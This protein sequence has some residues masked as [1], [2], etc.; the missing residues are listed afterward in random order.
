M[1]ECSLFK[2]YSAFDFFILIF[3]LFRK[4]FNYEQICR[5]FI[6]YEKL[7]IIWYQFK[8]SSKVIFDV[9]VINKKLYIV[10][11]IFTRKTNE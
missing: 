2:L 7:K 8:N 6:Y 10:F 9:H 3:N 4:N 5:T 11:K 1:R